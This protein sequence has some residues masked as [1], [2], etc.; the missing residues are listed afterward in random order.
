M[1][2]KERGGGRHTERKG[3]R[4]HGHVVLSLS[5]LLPFG[6]VRAEVLNRSLNEPTTR[7]RSVVDNI[8]LPNYVHRSRE[9]V[10][11]EGTAVSDLRHHISIDPPLISIVPALGRWGTLRSGCCVYCLV[12][13]VSLRNPQRSVMCA[14]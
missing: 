1:G 10:R 6:A 5:L 13:D 9:N 12:P 4:E 7:R 14:E 11:K 2:K 8:K 3:D